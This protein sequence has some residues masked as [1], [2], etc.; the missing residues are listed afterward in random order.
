MKRRSQVKRTRL[1]AAAA[2]VLSVGMVGLLASP[3]VAKKTAYL[4]PISNPLDPEPG[5]IAFKVDSRRKGGKLT[6]VAILKLKLFSVPVVC[7]DG[8]RLSSTARGDLTLPVRKRQFTFSY[9]SS[10]S[11]DLTY[12]VSGRVPRKGSPTGSI[13]ITG[14]VNSS[15]EFGGPGKCDSVLRWTANKIDPDLFPE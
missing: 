5:A 8:S 1:R 3:A 6:P 12:E 9:S 14:I 15:P 2:V 11:Y 4:G 10:G 7:S 13:R